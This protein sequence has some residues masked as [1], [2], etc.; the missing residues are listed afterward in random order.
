LHAPISDTPSASGSF[1]K[2]M[3]E[4]LVSHTMTYW[5]LLPDFP[6]TITKKVLSG[7]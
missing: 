2:E 6:Y 7:I 1:T 5:G 3:E 4:L